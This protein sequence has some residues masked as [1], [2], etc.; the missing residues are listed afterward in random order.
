MSETPQF[1]GKVALVT[2]GSRGIGKA[3]VL[4]LAAEGADVAF[5]YHKEGR[6]AREVGAAV[7]R[8]GR[9]ALALPS[10]AAQPDE[11]DD[12]VQ[13]TRLKLGRVDILV[14]N[15]GIGGPTGWEAVS[16]Q[17]W[18]E[19]L[20]TNLVG[21]YSLVR[22]ARPHFAPSGA[23]VVFISSIS[24]LL[25]DPD[26]LAYSVAKAGLLSLTRSLALALAP[27]V[28]VNAVAPGWVRT[29]LTAKLHES[30]RTRESIQHTIPRG[31]WGE[32]D[33]VA[34]A[35]VFLASKMARFV[36]GETLV[37]DG[38]NSLRWTAGSG[39]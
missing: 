12:L 28:R 24:G 15:A 34:A 21:P 29:D 7:E 11:A 39:D 16:L 25:A 19:T 6:A 37:V 31:R 13:S 22:A 8:L 35:V 5:S 1:A 38:G 18:R 36:T 23:S 27:S 17:A 9:R 20:E 14:G 26:S 10:D 32:P 2:G 30:P 3:I 4:A 33:D